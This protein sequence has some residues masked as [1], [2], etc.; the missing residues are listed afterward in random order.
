MTSARRAAEAWRVIVGNVHHHLVD[1]LMQLDADIL[2][3]RIGVIVPE[4]VRHDFDAVLFAIEDEGCVDVEASSV[5]G[6]VF[7]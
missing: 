3:L 4:W 6:E 7:F 2:N 5:E 1:V